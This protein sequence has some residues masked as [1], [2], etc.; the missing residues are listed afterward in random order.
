MIKFL[1]TARADANIADSVSSRCVDVSI[2][3]YVIMHELF[4]KKKGFPNRLAFAE[5][6]LNTGSQTKTKKKQFENSS[7]VKKKI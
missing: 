4:H 5:L 3:I 7:K 1:Q 2:D 6:K